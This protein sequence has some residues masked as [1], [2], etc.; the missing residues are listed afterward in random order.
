MTTKRV[1]TDKSPKKLRRK[2][3]EEEKLVAPRGDR[4]WGYHLYWG[5]FECVSTLMRK[6]TEARSGVEEGRVVEEVPER[7]APG[8]CGPGGGAPGAVGRGHWPQVGMCVRGREGARAP[9]KNQRHS[10][11]CS[12]GNEFLIANA[13]HANYFRV[14]SICITETATLLRLP[15][16]QEEVC[17]TVIPEPSMKIE[18]NSWTTQNR[19]WN[20]FF[21][22]GPDIQYFRP[23]KLHNG[24]LGD[25]IL[26]W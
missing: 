8:I 25:L 16:N 24:C 7:P 11:T 26:T 10:R 15:N 5:G 19:N 17:S 18:E 20:F 1:T 13:S 3:R 6:N 12:L 14:P 23:C 22:T 9:V 2:D 21:Y 4:A